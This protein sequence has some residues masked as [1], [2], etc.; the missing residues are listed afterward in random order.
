MILYDYVLS[1]SC[2]KVRLMASLIGVPLMLKAVNFHPERA[3]KS[4]EMLAL[5]KALSGNVECTHAE[6]I[7]QLIP[8][9]KADL[10]H[11]DVIMA[12]ASL[13][14]SFALLIDDLLKTY[15]TAS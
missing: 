4:P 2:Y 6:K 13:G 14:M 5:K 12:K 15:Q 8:L 9:I 7:D 1:A 10:R 3:H 11:G